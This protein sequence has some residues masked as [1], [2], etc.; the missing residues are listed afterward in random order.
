MPMHTKIIICFTCQSRATP[1]V[2]LCALNFVVLLAWSFVDPLVWQRFEVN[3]ESWNTYGICVSSSQSRVNAFL[4]VSAVLN[5]SALGLAIV[6]AWRART[7]SDEYSET[8]SIGLAIYSWLQVLLIGLPVL[9]LIDKDNTGARYFLLVALIFLVCMSML[10][11]IFIPLFVQ[12][13]RARMQRKIH[14]VNESN[15]ISRPS[16]DAQAPSTRCS[17]NRGSASSVRISG[18]NIDLARIRVHPFV[19]R[20]RQNLDEQEP[21]DSNI[22]GLQV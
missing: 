20:K 17:S 7:I 15:T 14:Q 1:L 22:T 2:V 5:L 16:S 13:R 12:I 6:Q 8:K 19:G 21:S 9:F 11:I 18:L 10:L 3:G 4:V